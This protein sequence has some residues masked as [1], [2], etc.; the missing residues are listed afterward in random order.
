MMRHR[1]VIEFE[2][3]EELTSEQIAVVMDSVAGIRWRFP[4]VMLNETRFRLLQVAKVVA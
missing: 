1:Y 2:T 4:E 3:D